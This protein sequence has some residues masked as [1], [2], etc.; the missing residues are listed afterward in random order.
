MKV[1]VEKLKIIEF[2]KI[3]NN[4]HEASVNFYKLRDGERT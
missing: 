2:V 4:H 1:S 3:N